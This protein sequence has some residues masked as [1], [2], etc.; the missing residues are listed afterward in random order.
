VVHLANHVHDRYGESQVIYA[1]NVT[2][3]ANVMQAAVDRGATKL[4]FASSIQVLG[5]QYM[6]RWERD[7]D[8]EPYRADLPYLPLD[9]ELP[10]RP[11]N[12]YALSKQAGEQMM[13][14]YAETA[15]VSAVSLRLPYLLDPQWIRRSRFDMSREAAPSMLDDALSFLT[16][17]DAARLVLAILASDLPGHRTYLPAAAETVLRIPAREA[18]ERY[19]SHV[20]LKQ[21][22]EQIDALV[23]VSQIGF[24]TGWQPQEGLPERSGEKVA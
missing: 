20:P 1:E 9:G 14:F 16:H 7:Q 18:I 24:D 17:T 23:D 6:R 13:A 12:A 22:I 11:R 10:A 4:I 5:G 2:T 21:P 15:Q 19:Y 3:N 8:D